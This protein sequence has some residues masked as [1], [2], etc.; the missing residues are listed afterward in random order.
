MCMFQGS[1]SVCNFRQRALAAVQQ[2]VSRCRAQQ[3]PQ[4]AAV[5]V[6]VTLV[7]DN[8]CGRRTLL[9]NVLHCHDVLSPPSCVLSPP[10]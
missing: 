7:L 10:S 9:K 1:V 5:P 6:M 8:R 3:H 4:T 2:A